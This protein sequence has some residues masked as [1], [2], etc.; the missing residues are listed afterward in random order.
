[1]AARIEEAGGGARGHGHIDTYT[2]NVCA[3]SGKYSSTNSRSLVAVDVVGVK[4]LV[5][6]TSSFWAR[7]PSVHTMERV[8]VTAMT[9]HGRAATH[10]PRVSNARCR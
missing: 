1:M 9:C 8:T 3:W 2:V 6:L 4:S 7:M 5:S 10:K